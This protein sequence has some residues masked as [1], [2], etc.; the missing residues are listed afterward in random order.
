[1][2]NVGSPVILDIDATLVESHSENKAGTAATYK[3]GFGFR[4]LLCFAG[5]TGETLAALL[6]P[7]NAG[8]QQRRSPV[9][10]G[11]GS[12]SSSRRHCRGPRRPV[13]DRLGHLPAAREVRRQRHPG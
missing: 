13:R 4:T 3:G 8:P 11:H 5:A 9:R 2:T 6:W 1:V 12:S 10:V 7:G